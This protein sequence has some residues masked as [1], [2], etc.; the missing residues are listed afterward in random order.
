M[1]WLKFP[2]LNSLRAFSV[3]AETNSYTMAAVRLNVT[4]AAVSQ[5]VKALEDHLGATLVVREG[6][7]IRLTDDGAVLAQALEVGFATIEQGV[8]RLLQATVER[9]VQIT[10]SP[11]F[12][13]EWLMPK[14]MEFQY[15]NPGITLML[16][17]TSELVELKPGGIDVAIRYRD[18]RRPQPDVPAVLISDMIVIGAPSLLA[19]RELGD[20]ASLVE[21][22]WLQ[23]LGTNEVAD[24]FTYH[25]VVPDRP[26]TVNHM[27]GNLIMDGV[28]RGDGITYTAR[29]FFREELETGKV[30]ELYSEPVFGVYFIETAPS[31]MRPA[32]RVFLDWLMSKAETVS[33]D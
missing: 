18:R 30:V 3:L 9:P 8:N 13:V 14:V 26:L 29:A 31:P 27:P 20:P 15:A 24:W 33:A 25:G 19:G 28:R 22:P 32:V 17:P 23:E 2:T 16:N 21:L 10:M 11:A 5:Q 4:H 1:D 6:R 12:A 7:G